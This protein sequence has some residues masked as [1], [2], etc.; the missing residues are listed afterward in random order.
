VDRANYGRLL[1][2]LGER[3]EGARNVFT[4]NPWGEYGH[5][6]HVQVYRAVRALQR[7]SG[8]NLWV[9][10]Y[11][12]N[13]TVSLMARYRGLLD[14][15]RQTLPTDKSLARRV[16]DL[17]KANDCWTWYDDYEWC[18]TE[19]FVREPATEAEHVRLGS[20]CPLNFVCVELPARRRPP[21]GLYKATLRRL[22]RVG[23]AM[24]L[25]TDG[26]DRR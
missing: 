9:N 18:D 2:T 11:C 13:E 14:G 8:F 20:V 16:A 17:Y 6:E 1:D 19:T 4:H 7:Q 3:L 23:N 22:K 26:R 21:A 5:V 10:T 25:P 15:E 12:S 24:G